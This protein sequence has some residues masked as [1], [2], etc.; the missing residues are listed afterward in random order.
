MLVQ[1]IAVF[2]TSTLLL[3]IADGQLFSP[4]APEP[5]P[6]GV[7]LSIAEVVCGT[8]DLS[9]LC[10]AIDALPRREP[11]AQEL[12]DPSYPATLFA[13]TDDAFS[14]DSSKIIENLRLGSLQDLVSC[15]ATLLPP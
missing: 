4:P 8:P 3:S 15:L 7:G 2:A 6:S 13:P 11:I 9:T 10:D 14:Q 12:N 1:S 5:A